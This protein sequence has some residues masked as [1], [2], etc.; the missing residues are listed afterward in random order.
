[1][2]EKKNRWFSW[3][4]FFFWLIITGGIGAIIYIMI[5]RG[6]RTNDIHD[7]IVRR[8]KNGR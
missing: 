7:T 3:G 5:K 6:D 8:S 1:M 4:W 2:K